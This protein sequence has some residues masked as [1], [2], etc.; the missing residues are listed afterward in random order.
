[1]VGGGGWMRVSPAWDVIKNQPVD[2]DR[3][4][5]NRCFDN[6]KYALMYQRK[7]LDHS[8]GYII[9]IFI[10]WFPADGQLFIVCQQFNLLF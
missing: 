1:M 10:D 2:H 4:F 7:T 6:D 9:V 3:L 8:V 5:G